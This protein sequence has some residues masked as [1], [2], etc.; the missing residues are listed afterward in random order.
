M[1]T[2]TLI[3]TTTT[4]TV[5]EWFRIFAADKSNAVTWKKLFESLIEISCCEMSGQRQPH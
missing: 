4:T 5:I 2:T 1:T 3:A